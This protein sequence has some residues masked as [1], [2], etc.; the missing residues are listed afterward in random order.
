MW[1]SLLF[2]RRLV[3]R[4]GWRLFASLALTDSGVGIHSGFAAKAHRGPFAYTCGQ[5]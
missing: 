1:P 4:R 2:A 5:A 3:S